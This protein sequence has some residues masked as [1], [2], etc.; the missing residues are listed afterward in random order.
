MWNIFKRK[1]TTAISIKKAKPSILQNSKTL[2]RLGVFAFFL[3]CASILFLSVKGL[4]GNPTVSD[5]QTLTWRDHGPF[6]LSPERGRFT[7]VYSLIEHGSFSFTPEL[8]RFTI[9]DV[10]YLNGKYVSLFA[11]GLSFVVLPGYLL[12]KYIGFSQVGTFLVVSLFAL[13]NVFLIRQIAMRL[14]AYNLAAT[15]AG[16]A[17]LFATPAFNYAVTLYQHHL[18]TF[19]LLLSIYLLVRFKS[20]LSLA[21]I[22]MLCALSVSVDY[23]NAFLMFPI[24]IA[25]LGK[26]F[27]VQKEALI[28]RVKLPLLRVLAMATVVLPL[29]FFFWAN[30]MSYGN[31]TQLAGGLPQVF[32][33][34][35]DGKPL[36]K[37]K[38]KL[39][40][41]DEA[42]KI[43]ANEGQQDVVGFFLS[44]NIM[45]GMYT[46]LLSPDRGIIVYTPLMVL[47]LVGVLLSLKRTIPYLWLLV[48]V[49]GINLILYSMWGDPWGGWAFGS[50]YLIPA[51]AVLSIFL[52]IALT[53]LKKYNMFLL[54]FFMLFSYSLS[55]NTVGALT[56]STNPPKS[57]AIALE[58]LSGKKEEYT[59]LRNVD[60]LTK[61]ES[62]SF[63][64]N[65]Y[66]H[67]YISAWNYY[68]YITILLIIV[69]AFLLVL[70]KVIADK[71]E[72]EMYVI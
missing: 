60:K 25:A 44:R 11:P 37:V 42:Q 24:G 63:V 34:R 47:A 62:R 5:L 40:T 70:Y 39:I 50:R 3:F 12:G 57:E 68:T 2:R 21:L 18:S 59:F 4:P 31:P 54:L 19:I 72:E 1:K 46:H 8:A 9:P 14:G 49:I 67:N 58:R 41:E 61:G 53:R 55:V 13:G 52:A 64:Y 30:N 38:E 33:V 45:N 43:I 17:F 66:A 65:T 26:T 28:T 48:T 36:F 16:F 23:P 69:S 10:A 71:K 35:T 15:L 29:V 7:L 22:W 6:E 27:L 56:S 51:Y 20:A 32:D